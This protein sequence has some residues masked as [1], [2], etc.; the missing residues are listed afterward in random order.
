VREGGKIARWTFKTVG[1]LQGEKQGRGG[2]SQVGR[3]GGGKPARKIGGMWGEKEEVRVINK[4]GAKRA[5]KKS[6]GVLKSKGGW[7]RSLI[8]MLAPGEEGRDALLDKKYFK[9]WI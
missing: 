1:F 2:G 5:K 9:D 4:G 6:G 3:G 8:I 7:G